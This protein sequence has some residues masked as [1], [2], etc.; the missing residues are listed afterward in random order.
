M[1]KS[2]F[3]LINSS[4]IPEFKVQES[5]FFDGERSGSHF[6]NS[7]RYPTTILSIYI[8]WATIEFNKADKPRKYL[9][10]ARVVAT[11]INY[12]IFIAIEIISFH[13]LNRALH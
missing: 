13:Y 8:P 1:C 12:V 5:P 2:P 3:I 7:S 11:I 6:G 10:S 4:W 9:F